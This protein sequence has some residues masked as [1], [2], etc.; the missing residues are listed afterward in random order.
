MQFPRRD[1]GTPAETQ[2][3]DRWPAQAH[4]NPFTL[5]SAPQTLV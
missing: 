5:D 2:P 4:S 3:E 1:A